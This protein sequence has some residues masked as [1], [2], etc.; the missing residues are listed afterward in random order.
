MANEGIHTAMKQ[1]TQLGVIVSAK[2][3]L[4][5]Y[6]ADASHVLRGTD[7]I[8]ECVTFSKGDVNH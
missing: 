2:T 3:N 8:L 6:W 1:Y 5:S 4:S 7:A